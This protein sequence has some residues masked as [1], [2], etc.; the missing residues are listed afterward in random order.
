MEVLRGQIMCGIYGSVAYGRV[1]ARKLKILAKHGQRRGLDA[2]GLLAGSSDGY[3]VLRSHQASS[4]LLRSLELSKATFVVGHS[5]LVTNGMA[6][7]QPVLRDGIAVIHNGIVVNAEDLWLNSKLVRH[8]EIDSEI[9]AA[10][11]AESLVKGHELVEAA[12]FVLSECRGALSAV[13][14]IPRLGQAV[15]LSNNG[16]LFAGSIDGDIYFASEQISLNEIE[17]QKIEQIFEPRLIEFQKSTH[18]ICVSEKSSS[19]ENLVPVPTLISSEEKNLKWKSHTLRRCTKCILP[20]TM[21]FISFDE[22]GICNYCNHYKIRN[23]PKPMSDLIQLLDPYRRAGKSDCIVPFSGGRDS[24]YALHLIV[25]ELGMNPIAYTYDWGMVTDLGRRNISRMCGELG[26]ENIV[27]AAN[28]SRKRRNIAMNLRAWL[29]SPD[30]GMLGLL[31][32]G[33]KH[34]FRYIED[35]KIQT[36]ISLNLWGVNPLEVTHFKSGFMGVEP[37]FDDTQVYRSGIAEQWSYHRRRFSRM[38]NSPGYFNSSLWD[39]LSGEYWRSVRR[40][41]DYFHVYDYWRWDENQINE[42]LMTY[43]WEKAPDTQTTWRIGDGTAGLYNYIY[44]TVAGFSE[45]DTFR[46]NQIREGELD[47]K[48]ALELVEEENKPRYQSIKWYL[49]ALQMDFNSVIETINAIPS[50]VEIHEGRSLTN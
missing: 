31:T 12:N 45:H 41:I 20:V 5:R 39:T 17:C 19:S 1:N 26:V 44:Y 34:F 36:D 48:T 33:D 14:A 43:E 37:N 32:A 28:I 22:L 15:L 29:K 10:I 46:S 6:D 8:L 27:V 16:S 30:L 7:N 18:E 38:T 35:V 40:K 47:R 24:S 4:K 25:K 21:P 13:I 50:M 23:K 9:I 3:Q 42:T 11:V 49:D 2:S